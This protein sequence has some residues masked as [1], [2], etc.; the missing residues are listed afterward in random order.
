MKIN[1]M[2]W[3]S[4][5]SLVLCQAQVSALQ[6]L[7]TAEDRQIVSIIDSSQ[8]GFSTQVNVVKE[9]LLADATPIDIAITPDS[10]F[11]YVT[12]SG[13]V[14]VI[15]LRT[16]SVVARVPALNGTGIA[17][18]PNGRFAYLAADGNTTVK[19]IDLSANTVVA[20]IPVTN[21]N[22][23]AITPDGT[24]V[25]VT[26]G[27]SNTVTKISTATNSVVGSP[28]DVSGN[29]AVSARRL[30]IAPNGYVFVA[31]TGTSLKVIEIATDVVTN[32]AA[33]QNTK[34]VAIDPTGRYAF[35]AEEGGTSE[36]FNTT[37]SSF[38]LTATL[39]GTSNSTAIAINPAGIAIVVSVNASGVL[40]NVETLQ[41]NNFINISGLA[42][43]GQSGVA[44]AMVPTA[45][46]TCAQNKFFPQIDRYITVTWED[47]TSSDFVPNKYLIYRDAAR[48]QLAGTVDNDQFSFEDHNRKKGETYT[49]YVV[50]EN[51][52]GGR[53][54]LGKTTQQCN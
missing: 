38:T 46:S 54:G 25:Y 21:A 18:T 42:S 3:M 32:K 27:A 47:A 28:I 13:Q 53:V 26:Q 24:L 2:L 45:S 19:V 52:L 17:I 44:A 40:F 4:G 9:I 1:K 16:Q 5:L 48:T 6:F 29:G 51:N 37:P 50:A 8:Y 11:A 14:N 22:Y 49:Y 43:L 31:T 23:V 30:A 12:T 35:V 33:A 39:S 20:S 36:V 7:A 15:S 34:A 10:E 41:N